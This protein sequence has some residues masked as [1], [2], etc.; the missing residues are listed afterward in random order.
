VLAAAFRA[1]NQEEDTIAAIEEG[2]QDFLAS[3]YRTL[4]EAD[5]EFRAKRNMPADE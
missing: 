2:N 3:R 1:L 4:E 5:A